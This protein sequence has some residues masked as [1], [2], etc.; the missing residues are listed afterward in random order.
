MDLKNNLNTIF[1]NE[2][3]IQKYK[4]KNYQSLY[5]LKYKKDNEEFKYYNY[6][7]KFR[8]LVLLALALLALEF[9]LRHTLLR[10]FI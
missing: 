1:L 6:E 4:D 2:H 3:S 10:S 5:L 8:P 7:E 9:S